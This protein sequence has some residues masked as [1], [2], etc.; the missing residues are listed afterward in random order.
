MVNS[1]VLFF[2]VYISFTKKFIDPVISWYAIK[3]IV[4]RGGDL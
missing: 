4:V 2:V 3:L 1:E